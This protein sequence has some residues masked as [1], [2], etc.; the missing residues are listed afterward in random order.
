MVLIVMEISTG[1]DRTET[2]TKKEVV[3][4]FGLSLKFIGKLR[5]KSRTNII[6]VITYAVD[7]T[8]GPWASCIPPG[9]IMGPATT[10]VNCVYIIKITQ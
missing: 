5:F 9:C 8:C 10:F 4:K 3:F 1:T 2:P 6:E 7:P